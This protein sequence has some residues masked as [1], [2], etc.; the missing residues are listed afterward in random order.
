MFYVGANI[1]PRVNLRGGKACPS[2]SAPEQPAKITG[3]PKN[4]FFERI[5]ESITSKTIIDSFKY[6]I[7]AARLPYVTYS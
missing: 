3:E 1:P 4:I 6:N 2:D 7:G 5:A